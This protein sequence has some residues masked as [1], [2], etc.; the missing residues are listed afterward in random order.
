MFVVATLVGCS[1]ENNDIIDPID[2]IPMSEKTYV[3]D[4]NFEE[5]LI[6]MGCDDVLDDYVLTSRIKDI[7]YLSAYTCYGYACSGLGIRDFTGLQ[8]FISLKHFVCKD[9][10][11]S[12]LNLIKNTAL[13]DLDCSDNDLT[14]LDL[15]QNIELVTLNCSGNRLTSLDVRNNI[16]LWRIIIGDDIFNTGNNLTNIDISE[17]L[18]LKYFLCSNNNLTKLDVSQNIELTSLNCSGNNIE[19][20]QVN[21][22]QMNN[23]SSYHFY[24][25]PEV[26][27]SIDCNY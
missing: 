1:D 5:L 16:N 10:N 7:E 9:N 23:I 8:D 19:C 21:L 27:Y 11:L 13:T 18:N 4:D 24:K 2:S 15:S 26:I 20:I 12:T 14:S 6:D 3:P 25:D 17:N 22:N